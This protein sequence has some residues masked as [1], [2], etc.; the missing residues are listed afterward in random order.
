[1]IYLHGEER[2]YHFPSEEHWAGVAMGVRSK[3]EL[4]NLP[5]R[6]VA[7]ICLRG[8]MRVLPAIGMFGRF[9]TWGD[10]ASS[11][12]HDLD[13]A[14]AAAILDGTSLEIAE[15]SITCADD[16]VGIALKIKTEAKS[17]MSGMDHRSEEHYRTGTV[18][19]Y[20]W[21]TYGTSRAIVSAA[22]IARQSFDSDAATIASE[23]SDMLIR[24]ADYLR[25]AADRSE[26][27]TYF[28]FEVETEINLAKERMDTAVLMKFFQTMPLWSAGCP[29]AVEAGCEHAQEVFE[30]VDCRH[31]FDAYDPRVE[32]RVDF[33]AMR[34]R[35]EEWAK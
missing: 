4:S 18:H 16:A 11:R 27:F 24:A 33:S 19:A 22:K 23:A 34:K 8:A 14:I 13:A 6:V 17:R 7:A 3:T 20:A 5:T 25:R 29:K 28:D 26:V 9:E 12:L 35:L 2:Y 1:M 30:A 21:H 10:L 31:V 15:R 32:Q